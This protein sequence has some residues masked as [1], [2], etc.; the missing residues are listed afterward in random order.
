MIMKTFKFFLL[1]SCI[2]LLLTSCFEEFELES[3]NTENF[4]SKI[5]Q[6]FVFQ[7]A[8]MDENHQWVSGWLID[9]DGKVFSYDLTNHPNIQPSTT[10]FEEVELEKMIQ[11]CEDIIGQ[12]DLNE[13]V[14]NFKKMCVIQ[15]SFETS[16]GELDHT[17]TVFY[18]IYSNDY[19]QRL[20]DFDCEEE[21]DNHIEPLFKHLPIDIQLGANE[22]YDSALAK[23]V[24]IW[25]QSINENLK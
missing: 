2:S 24:L 7:F 19:N 22:G 15:E 8:N 18:G 9:P 23:E 11:V 10:T 14:S 1:F 20:F 13:L 4:S 16:I 3:L 12:V 25:L 21:D 17:E 6:P 5:D